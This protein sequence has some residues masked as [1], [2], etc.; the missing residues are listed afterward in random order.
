V[1][2][3]KEVAPNNIFSGNYDYKVIE[4]PRKANKK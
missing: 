1:N 2:P 4:I 3:A